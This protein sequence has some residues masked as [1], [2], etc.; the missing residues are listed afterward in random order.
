M[1]H[2]RLYRL[3]AFC[4]RW[5]WWV[6]ALWIVALITLGALGKSLGGQP[7]NNFSIPGTEAQRGLNLL[8]TSFPQG[9][10]AS[11]QLIF[12]A[13]SGKV[14]DADNKEAVQTTISAVKKLPHV[15]DVANPYTS[16]TGPISKNGK[17]ALVNIVYDAEIPP[18]GVSDAEKLDSTVDKHRSDSLQ[19]IV[20]G[21]LPGLT[22]PDESGPSV[23]IGFV[24][25][26]VILLLL[27]GSAI[28]MSLP[29]GTAL[30]GIGVGLAGITVLQAFINVPVS[31]PTVGIMLGLGVG[32][33]YSLFIL[34]RYR[35]FVGPNAATGRD[36]HDAIGLACA[37]AGRA[38]LVAGS[39]VVVSMLGLLVVGIPMISAIAYSSVIVV[40]VMILVALTLLPA[41]LAF[42]KRGVFRLHPVFLKRCPTTIGTSHSPFWTRWATHVT[43]HALPYLILTT[44]FLLLLASPVLA[45]QLGPGT[46]ESYPQS[47]Q[48]RKGYDLIEKD[49]GPGYNDPILLVVDLP[50]AKGSSAVAAHLQS[51]S[52]HL[53]DTHNVAA[54]APPE[55]NAKKTVAILTVT[56]TT[57]ANDQGTARLIRHMRTTVIPR[58]TKGTGLTV[59]VDGLAGAYVDLDDRL[60][61]RL[62]LF[63][64][65]VIAIA[66]IILMCV[67][68]SLFIPLKAA[69][70]TLI[71]I[72]AAYGVLVA[73][74]QWGWGMELIGVDVKQPIVAFVPVA[75]FPILFGLSMD[76]EVFILSR[77]RE[78]YMASRDNG[79]A[80]V[81]GLSQT[82]RLVTS[83]AAIMIC[84]FLAFVLGSNAIIKMFGLG[85]ATAIF[86]DATLTR[87]ILLPAAMHLAGKANWWIP[88]WL[89]RI[90]PNVHIENYE[91]LDER[92]RESNSG[93]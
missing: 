16:D 27:F 53:A 52:S 57:D 86:V 49:F 33:D 42:T 5:R 73:V 26:I 46:D 59:Y 10:N 38:V 17:V 61:S 81:A 31:G 76:Y 21:E 88:N 47:S 1:K 37:T 56:P 74:F 28:A 78:D 68:R 45:M 35:E 69:I 24:C 48:L 41:F 77:I 72:A 75:M 34:S 6:L 30:L 2:G 36:V 87:M 71:S 70:L 91:E 44:L 15:T 43:T 14:T 12:H 3:G 80:V 8:K 92:S 84:V 82:A 93:I 9:S 25:A 62:I 18:L 29:I 19:V 90:L 11:A 54:V 60:G 20:S 85:L 58:V 23:A 51:L 65:T 55:F 79:Q 66:S 89:D 50:A 22:Q 32:I 63:I 39:T 13:R 64:L 83:A 4:A 7:S 40:V 67:F